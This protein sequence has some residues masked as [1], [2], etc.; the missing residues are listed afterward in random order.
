V[1]LGSVGSGW[2]WLG[3]VWYGTVWFGMEKEA[4]TKGFLP[5]LSEILLGKEQNQW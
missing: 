3:T 4:L 1:G 2:V 5:N